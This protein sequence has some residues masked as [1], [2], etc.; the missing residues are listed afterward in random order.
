M[1]QYA[2]DC[3]AI[4]L[5]CLLTAGPDLGLDSKMND[6]TALILATTLPL[7][8]LLVVVI[9]IWC[10][11]RQLRSKHIFPYISRKQIFKEKIGILSPLCFCALS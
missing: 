2:L 3:I 4:L 10:K 7:L 9:T 5:F 11:C 1:I 8:F 6:G